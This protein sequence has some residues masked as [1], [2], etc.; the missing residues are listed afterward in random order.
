MKP[1][2][3]YDD[4][5]VPRIENAYKATGSVTLNLWKTLAARDLK[6]GELTFGLFDEQGNAVL[7]KNGKA[8]TAKNAADG[9]VTFPTL[10]Y[11]QT[12]V[13]QTI[14][15]VAKEIIPN[16]GQAGYDDTVVYDTTEWKFRVSVYDNGDGTLSF[17]QTSVSPDGER[18]PAT[19]LPRRNSSSS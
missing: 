17:D 14:I 19:S 6:D 8:I 11:D 13:G 2:T 7:D 9:T 15:Y 3:V 4:G 5:D 12:N 10:T 1:T 18:H 16:K